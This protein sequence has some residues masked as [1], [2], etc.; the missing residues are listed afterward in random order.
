MYKIILIVHFFFSV[1]LQKITLVHH[2]VQTGNITRCAQMDAEETAILESNC[3]LNKDKANAVSSDVIHQ[4]WLSEMF[5]E[6]SHHFQQ[7][8]VFFSSC[9][10]LLCILCAL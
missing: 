8:V 4:F 10:Q 1:S 9:E 6:L 2:F 3:Q 5:L 7:F